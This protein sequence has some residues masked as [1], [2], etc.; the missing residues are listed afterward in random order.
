MARIE[1]NNL[2]ELKTALN[3]RCRLDI[4]TGVIDKIRSDPK[5]MMSVIEQS[6]I[7]LRIS[8]SVSDREK[9]LD[10]DFEI[11]KS[12]GSEPKKSRITI[13]NISPTTYQKL[14]NGTKIDFYGAFGKENFGLI[15][16]GTLDG[17]SQE[18][19]QI[20]SSTN[21]GF[22]WKDKTASGQN[23]VPTT[24]EFTDAG[25]VYND[26]VVSKSYKGVLDFSVIVKDILSL[27]S[28][29]IGKFDIKEQFAVK[30]YVARGK[31]ADIFNEIF[32]RLNGHW[33]ITNGYFNCY[34]NEKEAEAFGIILNS[35]NSNRPVAQE[36]GY[37]I[38][39][40]LLP[41]LNPDSY[42]KLNFTNIS[43]VYK[44]TRVKHTGN[45]YGT[46]GK[47]EIW[48]DLAQSTGESNV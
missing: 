36:S 33:D 26:A 13:W 41:F 9:G 37:K 12:S 24:I 30:N 16:T 18:E 48:C 39:T 47:T 38:E 1:K 32:N 14:E 40:K 43:G 45:N 27:F 6:D 25:I 15:S 7:A 5:L 19:N 35:E 11:D 3:F 8:D 34:P 29:P 20:V 31:I 44:I 4:H 23:D 10:I 21:K 46:Q 2:A 28:I 42:C 17:K 22:L